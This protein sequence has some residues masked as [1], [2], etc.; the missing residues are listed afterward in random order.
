[1]AEG[2]HGAN[3]VSNAASWGR[4]ARPAEERGGGGKLFQ[5]KLNLQRWVARTRVYT[6]R[7]WGVDRKL[8]GGRRHSQL[9]T[10]KTQPV[11]T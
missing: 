1:M 9:R 11:E 7:V 4:R 6:E 5:L 2:M 3:K 8:V 10:R